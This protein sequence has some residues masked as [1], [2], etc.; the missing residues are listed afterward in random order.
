[1]RAKT[2]IK[3]CILDFKKTIIKIISFSAETLEA[4][5]C[6]GIRISDRLIL[7][8]DPIVPINTNLWP[9]PIAGYVT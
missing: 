2:E 9:P 1:M 6:F 4:V 7:K 3:R 5:E 8:A